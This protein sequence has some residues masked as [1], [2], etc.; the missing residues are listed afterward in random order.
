MMEGSTVK[1]AKAIVLTIEEGTQ[2]AYRVLEALPQV[3]I[4]L[5]A[6]T[7]RLEDEGV[8]KF[9]QAFE[10]LMAALKEK[11]ADLPRVAVTI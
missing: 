6:L 8:A 9:N 10:Q 2:E 7:Q 3:G 1:Q 11:R 4:D 5:D